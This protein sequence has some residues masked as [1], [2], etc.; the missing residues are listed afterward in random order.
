M[1]EVPPPWVRFPELPRASM[2]WRMGAGETALMRF[3]EYMRDLSSEEAHKVKQ[4]YPEP[5][6]WE[7]FF[8]RWLE[9]RNDG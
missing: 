3:S 7:G 6:G 5:P 2:G 4:R 1:E 8:D 9:S